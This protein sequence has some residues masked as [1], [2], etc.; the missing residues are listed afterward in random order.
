MTFNWRS[1]F[2]F[3]TLLAGQPWLYFVAELTVFNIVLVYTIVTHERICR[4]MTAS[5]E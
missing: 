2:L 3:V 1:I 4:R 5:L